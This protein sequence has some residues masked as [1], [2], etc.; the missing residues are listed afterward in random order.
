MATDAV[1]APEAEAAINGLQAVGIRARLRPMERA[2]FYKADQE[3]QFK[4]LVRVGSAAAGNAATRIEAFAITGGN[5]AYG[6][7]PDI[8]GLFRDQATEMDKKKR[9]AM[10]HRI[11]QLMHERAMFAPIWDIVSLH[12]YGPRVA[13]PALGLIGRYLWSGPYEDVRLTDR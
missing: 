4:H 12:G 2:G 10:L 9:E 11:Q 1:Y 5:R 6:G 3:K 13:E 7:Y 8:D